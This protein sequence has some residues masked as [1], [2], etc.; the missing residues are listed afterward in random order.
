P[1]AR[2]Q[3]RRPPRAGGRMR[4]A[5][6]GQRRGA[7]ARGGRDRRGQHGHP[8]HRDRRPERAGAPL[9]ALP[10]QPPAVPASMLV[11]LMQTTEPFAVDGAVSAWRGLFAI[12]VVLGLVGLL[13]WLIRRGH[14]PIGLRS[15]RSAVSIESAVPLGERRSLV[16]VAVEGRRLMLGLTP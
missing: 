8:R 14:L 2:A 16:I 13:A 6:V 9:M 10:L 4:P 11:A 3:Q 12:V 1:D 7:G 15:S 5:G